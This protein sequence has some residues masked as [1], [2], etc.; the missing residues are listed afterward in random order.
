MSKLPANLWN[1]KDFKRYGRL[2]IAPRK[3]PKPK[4]PNQIKKEIEK[5][6]LDYVRE[7]P[8]HRPERIANELKRKTISKTSCDFLENAALPVYRSLNIPLHRVF[9]DNGK[10]YLRESPEEIWHKI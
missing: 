9:T 6:I 2:D 8:T 4:M 10:A 5:E 1:L 7:Y 3:R